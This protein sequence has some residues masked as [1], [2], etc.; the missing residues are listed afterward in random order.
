MDS[1]DDLGL[2]DMGYEDLLYF[3]YLI[4]H[5]RVIPTCLCEPLLGPLLHI[6]EPP[7]PTPE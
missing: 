2:I 4:T 6:Q 5:L 3:I 7:T 1:Y